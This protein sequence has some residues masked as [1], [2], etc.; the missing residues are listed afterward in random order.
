M[1]QGQKQVSDHVIIYLKR[2]EAEPHARFGFIVGKP[3]AGAVGRNQVKRRLR[4]ICRELLA[5]NPSNYLAV[6]RALPG[7]AEIDWNR[8]HEEVVS[9]FARVQQKRSRA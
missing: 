7:S 3:V 9:A 5:D 2:D 6:V 1:K 8:L 4:A